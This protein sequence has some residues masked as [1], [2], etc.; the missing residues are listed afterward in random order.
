MSEPNDLRRIR[1][2]I[3]VVLSVIVGLGWATGALVWMMVETRLDN[4][5]SGRSTP[6]AATTRLEIEY[7]KQRV[8]RLEE[9][10][11]RRPAQ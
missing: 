11:C 1:V 3:M 7:L 10:S 9:Q 2:P 8:S 6:M 5:E 4:L